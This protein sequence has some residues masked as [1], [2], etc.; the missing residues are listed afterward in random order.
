MACGLPALIGPG[1]VR[2]DR[3]APGRRGQARRTPTS[4]RVAITCNVLVSIDAITELGTHRKL[5]AVLAYYCG[6]IEGVSDRDH[7]S[8]DPDDVSGRFRAK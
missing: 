7:S 1:C 2:S 4:T 8:T 5:R 3:R 6:G